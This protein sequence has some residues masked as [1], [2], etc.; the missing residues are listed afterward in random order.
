MTI[1]RYNI[2]ITITSLI[3]QQIS[4]NI[5]LVYQTTER[6]ETKDETVKFVSQMF[7]GQLIMALEELASQ[8]STDRLIIARKSNKEGE[9]MDRVSYLTRSC[10]C[11]TIS[12][13]AFTGGKGINLWNLW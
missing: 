5:P 7:E 13:I 3:F 8:K 9:E 12:S 6:R 4:R 11:L 1:N 2:C 10:H